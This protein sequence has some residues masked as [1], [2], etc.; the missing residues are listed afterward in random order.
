M[1]K[2]KFSFAYF[3]VL[4]ML[5]IF[6]PFAP[7]Q[8]LE[9]DKN[10]NAVMVS[11][12]AEVDS[13]ITV[14]SDWFAI[15]EYLS[16]SLI[17]YPPNYTK[18]QSSTAGKPHITVTLEGSN[19]QTNVVIVDTVGTVGDSLETIYS[20]NTNLNNKKFW[21]YRYKYVGTGTGAFANKSDATLK[22]QLVF[23]RPKN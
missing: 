9:I 22:S 5:F 19:D 10:D 17:T 16:H 3:F 23:I 8:T 11:F 6:Q 2:S 14:T 4:A 12:D 15:P 21:Y 18:I 20:G 7:A 1:L 13:I